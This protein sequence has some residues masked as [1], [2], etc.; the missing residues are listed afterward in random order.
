MNLTIL[1]RKYEADA[2]CYLCR[3]SLTD[4]IKS[5]PSDYQE[6]DIQRGIVNNKYLDFLVDTVGK[7]RHIPP[8]VLVSDNEEITGDIIKLYNYKILDGLQRTHRLKQIYDAIEIIVSHKDIYL[9]EDNISSYYRTYSSE[10][11]RIGVNRQLVK[12]LSKYKTSTFSSPI[13]FFENNTIWIEIW[14][15][16][17][18]DMQIRKMLLLNAGH[19]S[20]NI[21]HQL[22]LLFLGTL[23]K[24]NEISGE[25]VS[26]KREKDISAIQYSKDRSLGEYHFSHIISALISFHAGKIVNTNADFIGSLQSGDL[27]EIELTEEFNVSF[28]KKFTHFILN[29]DR[30][31]NRE[32]GKDGLRWLGREVVLVGFF[33]ALG[34]FAKQNSIELSKL[35]DDLEPKIDEIVNKLSI[36]EFEKERNQVELNKV[37]IGTINKKAIYQAVYDVVSKNEFSSWQEYFGG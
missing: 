8:I 18:D 13:D 21:K 7:K 35:L 12:S 32:Y 26:F 17:S 16:L 19:K 37:N 28:L 31:L 5:I 6:F 23:L 27:P 9:S 2:T 34:A 30:S 36:R 4:Y 1:D 33:G 25:Q 11:K 10:F 14:C 22:E 24:L 29:L 3:V 20:V 15:G